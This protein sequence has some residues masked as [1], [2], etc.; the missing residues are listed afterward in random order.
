MPIS[1]IVQSAAPFTN[2]TGG[3]DNIGPITY[4]GTITPIGRSVTLAS[5]SN[6][7]DV[8]TPPAGTL[9]GVMIILPP[10]GGIT[11]LYKE[12]L[13]D[14][15]IYIPQTSVAPFIRFF[16]QSN[17]PAN[18]YLYAGSLMASPTSIMFF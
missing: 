12:V 2:I 5:G 7:I 1:L 6:T 17:L 13:N 15:G 4:T 10:A 9:T 8:P 16:D 11:C 3:S 14:T 18:I